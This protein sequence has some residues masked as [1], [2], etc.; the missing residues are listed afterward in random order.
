MSV[1]FFVQRH[2]AAL[3][4]VRTRSLAFIPHLHSQIELIY[5]ISG[6][7]EMTVEGQT[8]TLMPG[9]AALCWPN[10]VHSYAALPCGSLYYMGIFD[11]A[12]LGRVGEE[13]SRVDCLSPFLSA[14][15][16]HADVK[17][18]MERLT[19]DGDM[20]PPLKRAYATI[21][22]GRLI[23]SMDTAPRRASD[24][25][26]AL[27][28]VLAYID[29]NLSGDISLDGMAHALYMNKYYISKL[30]SRH[31]GCNLHAY[32]NALRV[33]RAQGLLD[34]VAIGLEEIMTRC[35]YT[36]ERTFYRAFKEH[37]GL[38]PKQYREGRTE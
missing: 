17:M 20:S 7:G 33:N 12:Q 21:A 29:E 14:D 19:D 9:E 15:R 13:F 4:T 38:T 2:D 28:N 26:D 34:D 3:K 23:E 11:P 32:M 25:P 6:S 18:A 37:T 16:V 30:F 1:D 10:R 27:H 31:M 8:H 5:V 22:A 36:S 35:G 24:A